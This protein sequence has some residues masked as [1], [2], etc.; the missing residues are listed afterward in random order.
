MSVG[1]KRTE[2]TGY[3]K[4][5]SAVRCRRCSVGVDET[6]QNL[7][8]PI[9]RQDI[10]CQIEP[11]KSV[12]AA[13]VGRCTKEINEYQNGVLISDCNQLYN[14]KMEPDG[15]R[16]NLNK[17]NI[18]NCLRHS[19]G[20]HFDISELRA[21]Q[22]KVVECPVLSKSANTVEYNPNQYSEQDLTDVP[23]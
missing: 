9:A 14:F 20:N 19:G 23:F 1:K 15:I 6:G 3:T 2:R 4:S 21:G 7:G 13:T 10:T 8:A 12:L 11:G 18:L 5:D 22:V 17:R 16:L